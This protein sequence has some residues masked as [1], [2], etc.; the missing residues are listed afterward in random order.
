MPL[1]AKQLRHQ[2]DE[3]TKHTIELVHGIGDSIREALNRIVLSTP[4]IRLQDKTTDFYR[5]I[6]IQDTSE[7]ITVK[8]S[9]AWAVA[10]SQG[11]TAAI[12]LQSW[13][14]ALLANQEFSNTI[15]AWTAD[16]FNTKKA[17]KWDAAIDARF[18]SGE[19][20]SS[21][22]HHIEDGSHSVLGAF[23]A[24]FS[25]QGS[26]DSSITAALNTVEHLFRDLASKSGINPFIHLTPAQ[27]DG[28]QDFAGTFGISKSW[29]NDF[30]QFN[31]PEVLGAFFAIVPFWLGWS[32]MDEEKFAEIAGSTIVAGI[33]SANAL[34][35]L[36]AL[37]AM[38][39]LFSKRRLQEVD[40]KKVVLKGGAGA[41][42]SGVVY[43]AS[44]IIEGPAAVGILVGLV[45]V[46]GIRRYAS[47]NMT[48][49]EMVEYMT[50]LYSSHILTS[51]YANTEAT[52]KLFHRLQDAFKFA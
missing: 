41:L 8:L 24:A 21:A 37:I 15:A 22:T 36:I 43:T 12:Q 32:K 20:G 4:A 44:A 50:Q 9:E 28:L 7:Q 10:K 48:H 25:V 11:T 52:L 30:L 34:L 31:A 47:S 5:R 46:Y 16:T 6:T 14:N 2:I 51:I 19:G 23:E 45:V 17:D 18:N 35:G 29:V 42:H 39:R 3:V 33:I 40:V 1:D 26:E 49:Q 38:A 27:L 13:A